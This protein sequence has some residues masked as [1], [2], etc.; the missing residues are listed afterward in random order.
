MSIW[1]PRGE[2]VLLYLPGYQSSI[3]EALST[4][5][6]EIGSQTLGDE[7][8][9]PS[10]SDVYCFTVLFLA[11]LVGAYCGV[12]EIRANGEYFQSDVVSSGT[13]TWANYSAGGGMYRVQVRRIFRGPIRNESIVCTKDDDNRFPL[14]KGSRYLLFAIRHAEVWK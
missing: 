11:H 9:S 7:S 12:P 13:A 3:C 2:R 10:R 4:D 14:E 5:R 1:T 8:S 6:I